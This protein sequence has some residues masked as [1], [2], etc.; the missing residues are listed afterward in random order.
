MNRRD[1][2]GEPFAPG[3]VEQ[4]AAFFRGQSEDGARRLVCYDRDGDI[5]LTIAL[6]VSEPRQ[7]AV[8]YRRA[9]RIWR[10]GGSI[11]RIRGEPWEGLP[12]NEDRQ[13]LGEIPDFG[14]DA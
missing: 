13:N 7:A 3:F 6:P 2:G 5:A 8:D 9:W 14:L 10:D 4:V 1:D 12:Q 11:F